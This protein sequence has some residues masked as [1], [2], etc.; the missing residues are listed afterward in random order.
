ML[1]K[2]LLILSPERKDRL[3][4]SLHCGGFQIECESNIQVAREILG[5][6]VRFDLVFLDA[7]LSDGV[8]QSLLAWSRQHGTALAAVVCAGRADHQLWGE[9]LQSG[10]YDLLLEPFEHSEVARVV[11]GALNSTSLVPPF[12]R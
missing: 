8:W 7:E 1:P 6:A 9:V 10:A 3:L 12:R 4:R 2:L 5:G 11:D